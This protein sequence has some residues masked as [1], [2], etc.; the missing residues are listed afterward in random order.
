MKQE[1]NGGILMRE[2]R[3]NVSD[4][5]R[6]KLLVTIIDRGRSDS[7]IRELRLLGVTFNM[8][9]VGYG[10]VGVDLADLLGFTEKE[11][12]IVYSVV[13]ES[14]TASALSMLEYK[15]SLN[16][17]G[18]GIAFCV[19]ISGVGGPVSLRYISGIDPEKEEVQ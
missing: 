18:R 13:T 14:K 19:P 15:F 12:D 16:E 2:R 1:D 5:E 17:P 10:A 4:I 3:G 6:V 8:A 11:C 9:S 7:L